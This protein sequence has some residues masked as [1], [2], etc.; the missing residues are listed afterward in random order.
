MKRFRVTFKHKDGSIH[1]TL[2]A[3]NADEAV[4]L[5]EQG[6]Q[7]RA[8][9]FPLTFSRLDAAE[10]TGKVGQLAAPA[11]LSADEAAVQAWAKMEREKRLRDQG[12]YE[13]GFGVATAKEIK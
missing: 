7:V 11:T 2:L 8:G 6:Q 5:A 9:R 1:V 4:A 12:R 10:E 3:K 13:T